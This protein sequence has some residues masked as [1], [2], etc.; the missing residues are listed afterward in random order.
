MNIDL[1]YDGKKLYLIKEKEVETLD[2]IDPYFYILIKEKTK[3]INA[4]KNLSVKGIK[5]IEET[6]YKAIINTK[7]SRYDLDP[8]YKVYKVKCTTPVIVPQIAEQLLKTGFKC[9][10]FNIRFLARCSFDLDIHFFDTYPLY[11]GLDPEI[12]NNIQKMKAL[13]IDVEAVGTKAILASCYWFSPLSEIRKDEVMHFKLPEER[14]EFQ[15][16]LNKALIISGHNI[17]GF[18]IPIL[19]RNDFKIDL[20]KKC[21]IDSSAVLSNWS[22]S[23]WIGSARSLLDVAKAIAKNVGITKEEIETKI[24]GRGKVG[25]MSWED[26]VKYNIND[27]VITCKIANVVISF[28]A[29][30]SAITQIPISILQN[31]TAGLV[32]EYYLLR[33]LELRGLI[34]EY[35]KVQ[36]EAEHEKVY[37]YQEGLIVDNLSK[38][39][40][41]MMYPTFTLKH[42]VDPTL[43]VNEGKNVDEIKFD[44]RSGIGAIWTILQKLYQVRLMTKKLK[45]K[46]PSFE[47]ADMGMKAIINS[48]AYGVQGKQS[49]YSIMGNEAVP[50]YI[51]L[52][53]SKILFETI[54]ELQEKGHKVI[55][56]DTDSIFILLNSK[57]PNEVLKDVN[58]VLGRY[59]LEADYE[60]TYSKAFIIKK[61]NYV[62]VGDDVIIKGGKLK[63][64]LKFYLPRIVSD[65]IIDII[66]TPVDQRRKLIKELI[67]SA[68]I[69]DIFPNIAQQF[70]RL[71]GKDPQSVK[72]QVAKEGKKY[73][74]VQTVWEDKPTLVLKKARLPN[75]SM[76]FYSPLFN[77]VMVENRDILYL[78]DYDPFLIAESQYLYIPSNLF[79]YVSGILS[80]KNLERGFYLINDNLYAISIIDFKYILKTSSGNYLKVKPEETEFLK[81]RLVLEAVRPRIRTRKVTI[82]EDTLREIVYR[83]SVNR[84]KELGIEVI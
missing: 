28:L 41:K 70:W 62:L 78:F 73:V 16:I 76:P 81:G 71:L 46:D 68:N 38:Y 72:R 50:K 1:K 15:K 13:I 82:S 53:T 19:K 20:V 45:K 24:K 22:S 66:K 8:E 75:L 59:G 77:L 84:I 49:G 32:A 64:N 83:I 74:K 67:Y 36:W 31:L 42:H 33:E 17:I 11:Y 23:F 29:V 79:K 80:F 18:D 48:L 60:G 34:P 69:E 3:I 10:A 12:M 30:V 55:Y 40:V 44:L 4:L 56:G 2:P 35:K 65:N 51:F 9:S 6:N 52:Q 7:G 37:I 39:D 5:E 54:K 21:V 26:L 14:D 61:K 43:I 58:E 63:I 25:K 57:D 47:Y 27:V